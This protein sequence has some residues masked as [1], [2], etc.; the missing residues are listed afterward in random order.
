M[1]ITV[2]RIAELA[3][4]SR[5]TVDRVLHNRPG[6]REE[7]RQKVHEI[8]E[9]LNYTPNLA[10]KALVSQNKNIFFGI[11][12]TPDFH[13]FIDEVRRGVQAQAEEI[14]E[15]G[16]AVDVQVIKSLDGQEQLAIL[17]DLEK[18]GVS[19]IALL[20]ILEDYIADRLNEMSERGI[21]IVTFNS[22]LKDTKR[23]CFVGQ[24]NVKAGETA[25]ALFSQI[26]PKNSKIALLTC[27]Y[28]LACHV[29]R[30]QGFKK[31]LLESGSGIELV[32]IAEIQ[33]EDEKAFEQTIK[34]CKE[35]PDL[36][37]IY[38]TGGGAKGLGN[39]LKICKKAKK[40][41]II[42]HDLVPPVVELLNEGIITFTI[43]QDPYMQ[44]ALPIKILFNY[45][46]KKQYPEQEK[47]YT[48]IDIRIKESI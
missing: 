9:V 4:V 37:G 17:D 20:P 15:F 13:P 8:V 28:E 48:N 45:I 44:G 11:I 24:D 19:G 41:K 32:G 22:D 18:R 26:L 10:G 33:D 14:K 38:L 7:V 6:V 3:G 12:L 29:H 34:F 46:F 30:V 2:N 23:L 1:K 21:P 25:F 35:F 40:V 43:G 36:G 39:A 27:S 47:F 42:S 31:G 5:G 16:V